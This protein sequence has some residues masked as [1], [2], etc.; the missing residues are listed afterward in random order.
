MST[1]YKLVED[2]GLQTWREFSRPYREPPVADTTEARPLGTAS[3][4]EAAITRK[5]R[6]DATAEADTVVGMIDY[7]IKQLLKKLEDPTL[8][9]K[10]RKTA[11][12]DL[13]RTQQK[14]AIAERQ[15]ERVAARFREDERRQSLHLSEGVVPDW[16][17][18]T[19]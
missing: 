7:E 10:Q 3:L 17:G 5:A 1:Y 12:S 9:P 16:T 11:Q 2:R 13:Y 6:Q 4:T 14:K 19:F 18:R 15:R 8:D